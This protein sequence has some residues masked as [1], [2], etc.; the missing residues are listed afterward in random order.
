MPEAK[1]LGGNRKILQTH[2][3]SVAVSCGFCHRLLLPQFNKI[4]LQA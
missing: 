3:L 1:R 4:N 2:V